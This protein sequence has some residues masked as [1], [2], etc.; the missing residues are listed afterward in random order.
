M[1]IFFKNSLKN[2]PLVADDGMEI[3]KKILA[4]FAVVEKL[5][6]H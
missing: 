2:I 4:A 1:R 6:F 3:P 5:C